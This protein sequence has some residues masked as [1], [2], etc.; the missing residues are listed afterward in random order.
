MPAADHDDIELFHVKHPSL[1]DAEAGE[2]LAEQVSTSTRP[3]SDIQARIARRSSS[4]ASST[5]RPSSVASVCASSKAPIAAMTASRC[6]SRVNAPR[7]ADACCSISPIARHATPA[8]LRPSARKRRQTR[9]QVRLPLNHDIVRPQA[10]IRRHTDLI[11]Q[12]HPQVRSRAPAPMRARSRSA[13]DR[14]S[15]SRKPGRVQKRH[16]QARQCPSAPRS[17]RASCPQ[18]P[19]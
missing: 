9:R 12:E 10:Q 7:R 18:S 4:A 13:P 5:C 17:H 8:P 6:R 19:R 3:T 15:V 11:R 16:R 1:A 2:N 14:S